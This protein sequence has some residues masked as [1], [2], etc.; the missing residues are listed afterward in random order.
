M[1][2]MRFPATVQNA[3]WGWGG[4]LNVKAEYLE[5]SDRLY[6]F[7][8]KVFKSCYRVE[9]EHRVAREMRGARPAG[10]AP[11]TDECACARQKYRTNL[12]RCARFTSVGVLRQPP[13]SRG[14]PAPE[15][16]KDAGT[17]LFNEMG[18]TKKDSLMASAVRSC[19]KEKSTKLDA[20]LKKNEN[21]ATSPGVTC[22]ENPLEVEEESDSVLVPLKSR[23]IMIDLTILNL[24]I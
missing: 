8:K 20:C 17:L 18:H 9:G 21:M 3:G 10:L 4:R 24:N 22:G 14:L 11:P 12:T 23:Q 19:R 1:F 13:A 7:L 15:L 16:L 2:L 6:L 5:E